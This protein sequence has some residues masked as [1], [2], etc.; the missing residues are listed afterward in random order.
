MKKKTCLSHLTP[1]M[2]RQSYLGSFPTT[3]RHLQLFLSTCEEL[4]NYNTFYGSSRCVGR[5]F[6]LLRRVQDE[7]A[8]FI[9]LSS[10]ELSSKKFYLPKSCIFQRII[11]QKVISSKDLSS[12][13]TFIPINFLPKSRIF[14]NVLS[15]THICNLKRNKN[16][17][18]MVG[19]NAQ[20]IPCQAGFL[21]TY[22]SVWSCYYKHVLLFNMSSVNPYRSFI[23][24]QIIARKK[25]TFD[26]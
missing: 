5:G 20:L 15:L 2:R 24:L 22:Q 14:Q 26:V 12:K 17:K 4:A 18:L 7:N 13:M 8:L 23:I 6:V 1:A 25:I 11:F 16:V 10:K 19:Q 21:T 9:V 3:W